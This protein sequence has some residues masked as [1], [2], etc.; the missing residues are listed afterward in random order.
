VHSIVREV[1]KEGAFPVSFD[2]VNGFTVESIRQVFGSRAGI[3]G[4][5]KGMKVITAADVLCL[6]RDNLIEAVI[7]DP[8]G[9][10]HSLPS[11]AIYQSA[12]RH[13]QPISAAR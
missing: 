11:N 2:K 6:R 1:E 3:S 4:I 9:V 5:K 12:P 8:H 13:N 7:A 10:S